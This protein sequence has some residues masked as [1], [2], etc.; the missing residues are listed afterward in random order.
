M[1]GEDGVFFYPTH[2]LPAPYHNQPLTL[3]PNFSYTGIF[4][5][6]GL[7][8]TNVPMGLAPEEGVPLGFQVVGAHKQDRNCLAVAV[9]LEK[10]IGGW[11]PPS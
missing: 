1:L 6:L 7:P 10:Q 3:I 5:V 8:A 4:N 9:E 11:V 2:P